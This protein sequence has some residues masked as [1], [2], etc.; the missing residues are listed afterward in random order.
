MDDTLVVKQSEGKLL[1]G[2]FGSLGFVLAGLIML[3]GTGLRV[4]VGGMA[5]VL[6]FGIAAAMFAW[7]VLRTEY[8][9]LTVGEHGFSDF[10][11]FD[12]PVPWSQIQSA[13]GFRVY[14]SQFIE[15]TLRNP[16]R[17]P[18]RG[19]S[20][21]NTLTGW[22]PHILNLSFL[23]RPA[24]EVALAFE[25]FFEDYIRRSGLAN[26]VRPARLGDGIALQTGPL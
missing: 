16:E 5:A 12:D 7:R 8:V 24:D 9:V 15:L 13:R 6:F 11:V 19:L 10:R 14:G 3:R 21:L 1:L 22:S 2:F 18:S 26:A 4:Q 20:R 25:G 17:Y 23:D